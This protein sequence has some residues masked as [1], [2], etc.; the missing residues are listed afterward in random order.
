MRQMI[1]DGGTR[2]QATTRPSRPG[3]GEAVEVEVEVDQTVN[4][5]GLVF[6]GDR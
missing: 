6:L 5:S 4:A 2:I 3:A 1:S